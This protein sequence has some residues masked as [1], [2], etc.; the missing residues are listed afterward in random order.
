MREAVEPKRDTDV[1]HIWLP[2]YQRITKL[3]DAMRLRGFDPII[4]EGFRSLA[5]QDWLYGYGRTHHLGKKPKTWTHDS[6]HCKQD[7]NGKPAA[8]AVDIVSAKY[9][10][11]STAF[12]TALR[13]E[14]EKIS[15]ID[16]L[17]PT[18]S[19][20]VQWTG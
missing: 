3:A 15:G 2:F 7:L 13:E 18:E 16:T 19:C 11:S 10:W 14:V 12:Y 1:T 8:K 9:L 5:R 17:Y 6:K 4:F 20:H